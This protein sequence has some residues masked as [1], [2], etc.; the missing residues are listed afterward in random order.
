MKNY[1]R[2]V[3][4]ILMLGVAQF[5]FAQ[6]IIGSLEAQQQNTGI[7]ISFT[8]NAGNQCSD[9][10]V[11]RS[12]DSVNFISL[13][14]FSG[15]CGSAS[16]DVGY[17]FTDESPLQN[18]SNYYRLKIGTQG[19]STVIS[20]H[21]FAP[22]VNGYLLVQSADGKSLTILFNNPNAALHSFGLFDFNGRLLQTRSGITE[23][24][25]ELRAENISAG[26]YFF[27]LRRENGTLISGKVFLGL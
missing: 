9:V 16:F 4:F 2:G 24:A 25:V 8:V 26:I 20:A 7:R 23:Q 3:L 18:V 19:F 22:G 11:Q 21:F 15:I 14:T 6:E 10:G 1:C 17:T 13:Y 5:S 12:A 27:R